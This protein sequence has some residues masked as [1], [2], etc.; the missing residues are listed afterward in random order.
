MMS[1]YFENLFWKFIFKQ[2][3]DTISNDI[4]FR[5][6]TEFFNCDKIS[7]TYSSTDINKLSIKSELV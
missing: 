3:N 2:N 6:S 5:K 4:I 1:T 7:A